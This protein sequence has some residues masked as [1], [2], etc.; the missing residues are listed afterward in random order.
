M[1]ASITKTLVR[2]VAERARRREKPNATNSETTTAAT[3]ARRVARAGVAP[4]AAVEA[5]R[6]EREVARDEDHRQR[7]R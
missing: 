6:D 5:E 3:I 4:D 2:E 7:G 1:S